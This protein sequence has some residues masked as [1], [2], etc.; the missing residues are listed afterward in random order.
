MTLKKMM[1]DGYAG[2]G[3]QSQA[4][5]DAGWD[6]LRIDN[7]PL[8]AD[9]ERMVIMDLR[10]A[11]PFNISKH[12]IEY[13]HMSPPCHQFSLAYNAPRAIAIREGFEIEYDERMDMTD[14]LNAKRIIDTLQPRYWSLENVRGAIKY[15]EPI[16]GPPR[17]IVGAWVYWGNFPMF[18]PSTI[19]IA[20]KANQD[21]RHSPLRANYRAHIPIEVSQAFC[22]AMIKQTSILQF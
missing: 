22:R 21:K 17:L 2:F 14:V 8:L 10:A 4:F 9:V 13:A 6:V 16:L 18:D 15:I 11:E 20:R 3:G 19:K 12:G 1:L 7:N 5:L